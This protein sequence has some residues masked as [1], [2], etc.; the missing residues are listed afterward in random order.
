MGKQSKAARVNKQQQIKQKQREA[1]SKAALLAVQ[2]LTNAVD[3]A[4]RQMSQIETAE[5]KVQMERTERETKQTIAAKGYI[6]AKRARREASAKSSQSILEQDAAAA[7]E[8]STKAKQKTIRL[9]VAAASAQTKAA[10]EQQT[11]G[12][13]RSFRLETRNKKLL[14]EKKIMT[15]QYKGALAV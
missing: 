1:E 6:K 5:H 10:N 8:S 13:A 9:V 4:H 3:S 7:K 15:E 11:K 2:Q 14:K 12:K